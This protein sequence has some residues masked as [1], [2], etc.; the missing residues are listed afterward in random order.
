MFKSSKAR[1]FDALIASIDSPPEGE[2]RIW[3]A[4]L[5]GFMVRV[6]PTGRKV[7]CLRYRRGKKTELH[8]IGKF[9]D[10]WTTDAAR[11][12]V[13]DLL[14]L[15]RGGHSPTQNQQQRRAMTV[16]ELCDRYLAE[17]HILKPFKRKASWK[18]DERGLRLHVRPICGKRLISELTKLDVAQIVSDVTDGHTARVAKQTGGAH[19]YTRGGAGVARAVRVSLGGMF[20]WAVANGLM[21][22]NPAN[23]VQTRKARM[24]NRFLSPAEVRKLLTT[25]EKGVSTGRVR[26]RHAEAIRLLLL[27][28]A[29]KMEIVGLRWSEV[30]L[31]N[32]RLEIPPERS[33]CGTRNGVRR[34]PLS[35]AA[36]RILANIPRISENVF[37]SDHKNRLGVIPLIK[38]DS[39][40]DWLREKC[41]FPELRVHDLRHSFASFA[42]ANGESIFK[43]GAILGH[44]S[45][46]MTERYLHLRDD[47]VRNVAERTAKRIMRGASL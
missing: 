46:T 44:A 31:L 38:L 3:D 8:T 4:D 47:D 24:V 13:T 12:R 35:A 26:P 27:T 10:P 2:R 18:Q 25:L 45:T 28:G 6:W 15:F 20:S 1:L 7:F 19:I 30:D 33:K 17:G 11:Q 41:G 22:K 43:I 14:T 39:P 32:K 9:L 5:G 42:V 29:R 36:I 40:W 23:G 34:I 16:N 37:P 21:D